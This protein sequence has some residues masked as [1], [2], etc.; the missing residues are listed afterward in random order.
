MMKYL[1]SRRGL[2]LVEAIVTVMILS[3]ISLAIATGLIVATRAQSQ[4]IFESES[5]LLANTINLALS[6]V[7]R[8]AEYESNIGTTNVYFSN[9]DYSLGLEGHL[10]VEDGILVYRNGTTGGTPLVNDYLGLKMKNWTLS[11]SGGVFSGGYELWDATDTI[12]RD[13]FTFAFKTLITS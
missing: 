11:Y 2:T 12:G 13:D 1:R 9:N 8:Y 6:D 3:L 7:L 5:G 4:S 10:T